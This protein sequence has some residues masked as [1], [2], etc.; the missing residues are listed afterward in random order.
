M[1]A[2]GEDHDTAGLRCLRGGARDKFDERDTDY[3]AVRRSGAALG[4][5]EGALPSEKQGSMLITE[6]VTLSPS[7]RRRRKQARMGLMGGAG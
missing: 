2:D 7:L 4:L 5:S 1:N 3:K 6:S